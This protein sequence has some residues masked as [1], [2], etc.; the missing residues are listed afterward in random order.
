MKS[1]EIKCKMQIFISSVWRESKITNK[2]INVNK[3]LP[4]KL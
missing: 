4:S 2:I 1:I 3:I